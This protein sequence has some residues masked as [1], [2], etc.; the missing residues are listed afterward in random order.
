M[1]RTV[2]AT[3]STAWAQHPHVKQVGGHASSCDA[4]RSYGVQRSLTARAETPETPIDSTATMT[5]RIA[6]RTGQV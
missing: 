4:D 3:G 6:R 2:S 1:I 5:A